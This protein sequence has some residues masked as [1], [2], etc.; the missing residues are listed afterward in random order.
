MLAL[1]PGLAPVENQE[2]VGLEGPKLSMLC[3]T[4]YLS[5]VGLTQCNSVKTGCVGQCRGPAWKPEPSKWK[6]I[7]YVL[8]RISKCGNSAGE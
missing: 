8:L 5:M 4:S 2:Q 7:P 6:V 3:L 1:P